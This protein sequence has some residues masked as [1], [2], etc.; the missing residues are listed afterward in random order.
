MC[1]AAASNASQTQ[2]TQCVAAAAIQ[3]V[4]LPS[5]PGSSQPDGMFFVLI[6]KDHVLFWKKSKRYLTKTTLL[7]CNCDGCL[8]AATCDQAAPSK[9]EDNQTAASTHERLTSG[10]TG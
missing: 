2:N 10:L 3:K 1:N 9:K 6:I 7:V 8:I 5:L 4:N